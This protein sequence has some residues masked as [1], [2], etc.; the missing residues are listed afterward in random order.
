[1][2]HSISDPHSI[3]DPDFGKS[4]GAIRALFVAILSR[5]LKDIFKPTYGERETYKTQALQ[6]ITAD[7][8]ESVTSFINICSHLDID[9][10]RIRQ[11]IKIEI[12]RIECGQPHRLKFKST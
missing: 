12:H 8:A 1:M 11:R 4:P 10:E 3:A 2:T 6:W 9:A 7:D 5:A